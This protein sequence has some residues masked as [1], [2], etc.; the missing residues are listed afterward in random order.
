MT[1]PLINILPAGRS[2]PC[3]FIG[4][5]PSHNGFRC[6]DPIITSKACTTHHARIDEINFPMLPSSPPRPLHSLDYSSFQSPIPTPDP[7]LATAPIFPQQI[8]YLN[9]LFSL[10]FVVSLPTPLLSHCR[11]RRMHLQLILLLQ[12]KLNTSLMVLWNV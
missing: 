7:S 10:L 6:L 2:M 9:P 5:S 4:Y 12:N 11:F 1:T 3:I 8:P